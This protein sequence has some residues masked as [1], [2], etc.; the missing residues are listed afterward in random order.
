LRTIV[1][2]NRDQNHNGYSIIHVE[3]GRVVKGGSGCCTSDL[4]LVYNS[5]TVESYKIDYI[6]GQILV[7]HRQ[8][9]V[10]PFDE[11]STIEAIDII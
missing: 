11:L 1:V 5:D 7:R 6:L 10:I 9:S 3:N 8:Q 4:C 2:G